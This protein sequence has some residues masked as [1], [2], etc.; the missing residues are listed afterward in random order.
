MAER[1][2][3]GSVAVSVV[4]SAEEFAQKLRDSLLGDADRIG[5]EVGDILSAR[6]NEKLDNVNVR[7]GVSDGVAQAQLDALRAKMDALNG[8]TI[9]TNVQVNNAS[10]VR[11]WLVSLIAGAVAIAPAFAVAAVGVTAFAGLAAPALA[12]VVKYLHDMSIGSTKAAAD[13]QALTGEQRIMATEII[14]LKN[15][16]HGL[17]LQLQPQLLQ[18]FGIALTDIEQI[19]PLII[20]VAKAA[21]G[22][23]ADLLSQIGSGLTDSQAQQFFQFVAKNLGPDIHEIGVV[24]VALLHTIF[25]LTEAM[26]PLSLALLHAVAWFANLLSAVSHAAPWLDDI[27]ITSIALYKPLVALKTLNLAQSFA[28]IPAAA[29]WMRDFTIA[30]EGATVAEKAQLLTE[31]ALK[32]IS[33]WGFAIAGVALL[34]ALYYASRQSNS[35]I[36]HL[37]ASLKQQDQAAGFNVA[38]FLKLS[39]Q[40]TYYQAN[41][42]KATGPIYGLYGA[43]TQVHQATE[44]L[45]QA[46]KEASSNAF[47]LSVNLTELANKYGLSIPQA[48]QVASTQKGAAAAFA[49]GGEAA[50]NMQKQIDNFVTAQQK[51]K[52]PT[53]LFNQDLIALGNN[54]LGATNQVKSLTDAF[55]RMI[56][57]NLNA[58]D[59]V[60]AMKNDLIQLNINLGKSK[61]A[62][63]DMGQAQRDSFGTFK[64]YIGDVNTLATDTLSATGAQRKHD[65]QVLNNSI[66]FL[67]TLAKKNKNLRGE[68]DALITIIKH[69]PPT[70]NV[71]V[72]VTGTGKWTIQSGPLPGL[73]TPAPFTTLPTAARGMLVTTGV[74]G[75][76]D[77]LILAQK[78]EAIVPVHAV[79]AVAPILK[80]YGVPGFDAGGIIGNKNYSNLAHLGNFDVHNIAATTNIITQQTAQSLAHGLNSIPKLPGGDIGAHGG[81]AF[82]NQMIATALLPLF[83]F[84]LSQF[85]FLL[86]LWNRE[87]GW[88][89]H[90]LNPS[91]G[92][93]GIPQSLPANKMASAGPDWLT[94]AVT[95]ERWGLGYIRDRYG[96]PAGAWA[97]ELSAGW[98]DGGGWAPP[99]A[100]LLL[101]GTGQPEPVFSPGQWDSLSQAVSGAH[102]GSTYNAYFTMPD[103]VFESRIQSAF[104][105][106]DMTSAAR[107]RVGRRS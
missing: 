52:V 53:D 40:L 12:G 15:E 43:I 14:A 69:I 9:E 32:A 99:G 61:G 44:Q 10:G 54:A 30:T 37:V 92:A 55:N 89:E 25:S 38:G 11:S 93:Y 1:I 77:Q 103:A 24:V 73:G 66:P 58:E 97:H 47:N 2:L 6:I 78:G 46:Q 91:S 16:F 98:Y 39:Q 3:I 90:A 18:I 56:A 81:T 5:V 49:A 7:V 102:G 27:L 28:W 106:M 71:K 41:L 104:R 4:P 26:Q 17:S 101:N 94:N 95:Q 20:P 8:K 22:A 96:S 67:E 63:G 50:A 79:P 75:I 100:S 45:S 76:D 57:P 13:W 83:G 23:I 29:K 64:T 74:P 105:A 72:G 70:E 19:L 80:Q 31:L 88:N 82:A 42:T 84:S 86:A 51:A 68:I 34:G 65:I 87:S 21:G 60:V 62:I 85:P 48:I 33:P 107:H 35:A 59:A 36:D